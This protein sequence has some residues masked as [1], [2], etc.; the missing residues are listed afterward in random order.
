MTVWH[1]PLWLSC[2][3]AIGL[4]LD[5][6][7]RDALSWIAFSLTI[8]VIFLANLLINFQRSFRVGFQSIPPVCSQASDMNHLNIFLR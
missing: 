4:L 3:N 6:G 7:E 1:I 8:R 2:L 5:N